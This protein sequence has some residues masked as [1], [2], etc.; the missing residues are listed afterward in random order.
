M[1]RRVVGSPWDALL[2][3]HGWWH[4]LTGLGCY[5]F[6]TL[7]MAMRL[8]FL[9]KHRKYEVRYYKRTVP[10]LHHIIHDKRVM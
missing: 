3:L 8:Y 7:T 10:Y 6:L 1:S 9:D 2:Q 4:V 5:G